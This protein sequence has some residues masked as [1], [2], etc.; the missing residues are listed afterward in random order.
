VVNGQ[1]RSREIGQLHALNL[2]LA[3]YN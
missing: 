3:T 2:Q 1:E